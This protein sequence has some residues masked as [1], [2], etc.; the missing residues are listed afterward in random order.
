MI[1]LAEI[2]ISREMSQADFARLMDTS[3]AN[4]S[5]WCSG[6]MEPTEGSLLRMASVLRVEVGE[7]RGD[8]PL[9]SDDERHALRAFR[10]IPDEKKA[11]ALLILD[12][13]ADNAPRDGAAGS[14][15]GDNGAGEK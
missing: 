15:S 4:V 2:L 3:P 6:K 13:L 1:K 7:I 11:S 14:G 9:L 12:T 5:R 8:I 10:A